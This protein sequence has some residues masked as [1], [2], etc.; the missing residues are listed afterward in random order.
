MFAKR[1]QKLMACLCVATCATTMIAPAT[2]TQAATNTSTVE[3]IDFN[4]PFKNTSIGAFAEGDS[5]TLPVF[6]TTNE[7]STIAALTIS[8]EVTPEMNAT[9]TITF[10]KDVC[11]SGLAS[12]TVDQG[13]VDFA[14]TD[15]TGNVLTSTSSSNNYAWFSG[16]SPYITAG[17]YTLTV[18]S[19]TL[20]GYGSF[21]VRMDGINASSSGTIKAGE[22][23]LGY[24]NKTTYKKFTVSSN[25]VVGITAFD[26][27]STGTNTSGIYITICN[28]K[29]K[30]ISKK[31][32]TSSSDKYTALFG[33][34]K[35]TYYVKISSIGTYFIGL[36]NSKKGTIGATSKK[37]AKKITSSYKNY[38][39]PASTSKSSAWFKYNMKKSAKKTLSIGYNGNYSVKA[40]I[41][42]GSKAVYTY[43][44][45]NGKGLDFSYTNLARTKKVKWQTGTYYVKI[46]KNQKTDSGL[47]SIKIK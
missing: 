47:I 3:N 34:K 35:G 17:T 40:T 38:I 29:K 26:S 14:I 32:C 9:Y 41:Y 27:D 12:T 45:Y 25:R 1:I 19:N 5:Y 28:S 4:A 42:K 37:K 20:T 44:I 43:T 23:Y 16:T 33:L 13:Y 11:F 6:S 8:G 7:M 46:S 39:I 21:A 2:P 30:A 36:T 31:I 10:P 15:S 18:Q 24:N 22:N